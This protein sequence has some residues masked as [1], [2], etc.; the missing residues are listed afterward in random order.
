M[1]FKR[2]L[3]S[4]HLPCFNKLESWFFFIEWK[5]RSSIEKDVLKRARDVWRYTSFMPKTI[6]LQHRA[7]SLRSRSLR[8]PP[9]PR[10]RQQ[11]SFF[12]SVLVTLMQ[13]SLSLSIVVYCRIPYSDVIAIVSGDDR[14]SVR[15]T[16]CS[17]CYY[18]TTTQKIA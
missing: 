12:F 5:Y 1:K 8:S 11:F 6:N 9:T 14:I 10:C 17:T 7:L 18:A 16:H 15:C 2:A 3:M 4:Q 13:L